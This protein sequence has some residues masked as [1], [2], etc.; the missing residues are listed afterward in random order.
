MATDAAKAGVFTGNEMLAV[1]AVMGMPRLVRTGEKSGVF[2]IA[3][4]ATDECSLARQ[5]GMD[6]RAAKPLGTVVVRVC[7]TGSVYRESIECY[8]EVRRMALIRDEEGAFK[9]QGQNEVLVTALLPRKGTG[10]TGRRTVRV[11]TTDEASVAGAGEAPREAISYSVL[12]LGKDS[13]ADDVITEH[14][15]RLAAIVGNDGEVESLFPAAALNLRDG[16]LDTVD[17]YGRPGNR[18]AI[19]W[20]AES[21]ALPAGNAAE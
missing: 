10:L 17:R 13:S 6:P 9:E 8:S 3:N 14:L 16:L 19:D 2:G 7:A 5:A 18:A 12:L 20:P 11:A 21:N 15:G 4:H 1:D